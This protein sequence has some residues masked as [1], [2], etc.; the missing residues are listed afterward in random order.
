MRTECQKVNSVARQYTGQRS[1]RRYLTDYQHG[2]TD[3]QIAQLH[4]VT[5]QA[6]AQW[7]KRHGLPSKNKARTQFG[8]GR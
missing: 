7:R 4:R 5:P 6:I 1:G 2:F 3:L 8:G